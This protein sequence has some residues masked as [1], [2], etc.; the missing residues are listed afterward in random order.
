MTSPLRLLPVVARLP[1]P[2]AGIH[3]PELPRAGQSALARAKRQQ[4]VHISQPLA[5]EIEFAC[6]TARRRSR[7][8]CLDAA[9]I[10]ASMV[11][12]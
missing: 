2:S 1:A 7:W 6:T 10:P 11:R 5:S 8:P 9:G 3:A 12:G 4:R